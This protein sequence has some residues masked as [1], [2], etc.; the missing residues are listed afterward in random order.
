[1]LIPLELVPFFQLTLAMLLGALIGLERSIAHKKAGMR[2]FGLVALGSCFFIMIPEIAGVSR[3]AIAFDP[4]RVMAAVIT[5][6]GFIGGGLIIYNRELHGL[7]TS[8]GL[9]VS[10]GVGT[11]VGFGLYSIALFNCLLTLFTFTVM[12]YVER[13]IG[14][15]LELPTRVEKTDI[16]DVTR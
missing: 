2:T 11:A 9:W 10:A 7:T 6:I 8:A 4:F 13:F 16:I 14:S 15:H 1:M 12:W 5:G 3:N